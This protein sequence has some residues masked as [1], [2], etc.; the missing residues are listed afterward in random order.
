M[1]LALEITKKHLDDCLWNFQV[2]NKIDQLHVLLSKLQNINWPVESEYIR[3]LIHHKY[4]HTFFSRG[5]LEKDWSY[6]QC[7]I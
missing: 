4:K 3:R 1:Y 6:S 5:L 7:A 2:K